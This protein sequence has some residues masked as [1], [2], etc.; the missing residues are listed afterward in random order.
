MSRMLHPRHRIDI[1]VDDLAFALAACARGVAAPRAASAL[2]E[3][4]GHELLATH[5]VRSGFDLLLDALALEPGDEVMLSALTIPDMARIV[6]G[7]G[8]VPIPVDVPTGLTVAGE[9]IVNRGPDGTV[10]EGR[11][12]SADT[13][14]ARV[15]ELRGKGAYRIEVS[16]LEAGAAG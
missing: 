15:D 4:V 9:I 16:S 13:H 10:H 14:V 2:A 6:R 8:L 3:V 5:S 12:D 7:R 11:L 1:G